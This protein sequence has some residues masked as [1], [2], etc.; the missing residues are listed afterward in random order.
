MAGSPIGFPLEIHGQI[1]DRLSSGR[2]LYAYLRTCRAIFG[3]VERRLYRKIRLEH[4]ELQKFDGFIQG[5]SNNPHLLRFV[6]ELWLSFEYIQDEIVPQLT[7][8]LAG[9][10]GLT[11]LHLD[12]NNLRFSQLLHQNYTFRLKRFEYAP[13]DPDITHNYN[14]PLT[15]FLTSQSSIKHLD[16][17]IH[18]S[19]IPLPH[20][21]LPNLRVLCGTALL[22]RSVMPGRAVERLYWTS[23]GSSSHRLSD[24][25]YL[26]LKVLKLFTQPISFALVKCLNL[27]YLEFRVS[28]YSV[29]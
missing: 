10:V 29:S 13:S 24:H 16:I 18:S 20:T 19:L 4:C 26:A 14:E 7:L 17:A 27:Q 25:A 15:S 6:G 8:A 23:P 2:D 28:S 9:M 21:A 1:S 12:I 3:E 22:A 11:Y 5:L